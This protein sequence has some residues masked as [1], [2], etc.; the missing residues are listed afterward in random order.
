M[1]ERETLDNPQL[2][3]IAD[4]LESQ[5]GDDVDTEEV[6]DAVRDSVESLED[7]PVRTYVHSL[8]EHKAR[9][10]L[11]ELSH[12]RAHDDAGTDSFLVRQS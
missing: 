8:A 12:E 6:D 7:A 2:K 10:R 11:R 5:F 9:N 3:A 1:A 4:R